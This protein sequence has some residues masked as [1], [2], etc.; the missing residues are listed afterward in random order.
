MSMC[1]CSPMP[2]DNDLGAAGAPA[3]SRYPDCEAHARCGWPAHCD[4]DLADAIKGLVRALG[5][6][7]ES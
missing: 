6:P 1:M 2:S 3:C 4:D 7:E 5:G